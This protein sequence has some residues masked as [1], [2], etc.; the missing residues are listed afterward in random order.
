MGRE[1][2]PDGH[3]Q[4][5]KTTQ[6]S[7][8]LEHLHSSEIAPSNTEDAHENGAGASSKDDQREVDESSNDLGSKRE[9]IV[10]G[11]RPDDVD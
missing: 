5:R 11:V 10:S 3:R 9:E 1:A 6:S 4:S 2:D 8:R 7:D